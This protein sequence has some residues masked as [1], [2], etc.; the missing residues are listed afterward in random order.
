MMGKIIAFIT[1]FIGVTLLLIVLAALSTSTIFADGELETDILDRSSVAAGEA[2]LTLKNGVIK[3]EA[4]TEDLASGHA[5]SVWGIVL[6]TN[7]TDFPDGL[8][9]FNLAGFI[10]DDDGEAD[11]SGTAREGVDFVLTGDTGELTGFVIKIKDHGAELS[12]P[13]DVKQQKTT[14]DFNCPPPSCPTVQTG[15]FDFDDDED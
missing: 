1:A 15:V 10:T 14:K 11:F 8:P 9:A 5:F 4:E 13:E 6:T 2:T 12:A 7:T 3:I